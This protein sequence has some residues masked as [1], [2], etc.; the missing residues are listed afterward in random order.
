[1]V[2]VMDRPNTRAQ[3]L[4]R[5]KLTQHLRDEQLIRSLVDYLDFPNEVRARKNLCK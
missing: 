1:M 5:F 2:R 3:V 4:L